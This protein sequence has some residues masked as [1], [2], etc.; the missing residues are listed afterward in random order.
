MYSLQLL[1]MQERTGLIVFVGIILFILFV[2]VIS[3]LYFDELLLFFEYLWMAV[4]QGLDAIQTLFRA[5]FETF[6]QR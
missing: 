3:A 1:D 2:Y 5:I 4:N 6:V